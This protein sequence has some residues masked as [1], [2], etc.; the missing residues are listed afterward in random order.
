MLRVMIDLYEPSMAEKGLQ[1]RLRSAGPR[2]ISA[3]AALMHRMISNLLDNELNHLPAGST[4]S[5]AL[6]SDSGD[7]SLVIEDDGPG[8]SKDIGERLFEQGVKGKDSRGHG[9]GL[10]FVRA[11][12]RAHGGSVSAAN[13]QEGGARLSIV[14]PMIVEENGAARLPTLIAGED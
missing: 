2:R 10:A 5:L 8:F 3:D 1:V 12:V 6:R 7:A 4:I 9:L 11:V 14:L 13:R